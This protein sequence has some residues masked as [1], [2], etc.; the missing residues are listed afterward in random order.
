MRTITITLDNNEEYRVPS[1]DG[2]EA[3]AYYTDD[4]QDAEDTALVMYGAPVADTYIKV[5]RVAEHP[6]GV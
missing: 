5:K 6:E 4:R 2:S 1:L 3:G